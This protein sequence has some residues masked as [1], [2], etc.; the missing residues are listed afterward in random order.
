MDPDNINFMAKDFRLEL[1][2]PAV[3]AG[4]NVPVFKDKD[5]GER[6]LG[7]ATD[8]GAFERQ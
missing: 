4:T 2:S 3:N 8:L 5:G 6:T 7:G 1:S